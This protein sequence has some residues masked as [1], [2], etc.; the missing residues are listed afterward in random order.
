LAASTTTVVGPIDGRSRPRRI[1]TERTW[2]ARAIQNAKLDVLHHGGGTLPTT[3]AT[4][5]LPT[6]VTMHDAQYL[7]FPDTFSKAKLAWLRYSV[8]RAMRA[9]TVVATPSQYV[10]DTIVERFGIASDRVVVVPNAAPSEPAAGARDAD[11][12]AVDAVRARYGL[13][14][15]FVVYPAITYAHKNHATLLRAFVPLL[16]RNHDRKLVLLGGT[17]P[18]ERDVL[19]LVTELGLTKSVVRPGRVPASDRDAL[20]RGA[21]C[22][23]FPSRYEGFGVPVLEA[24]ALR[25]PVVASSST[26]LPEAVGDAGLL[27]DPDDVAGWSTAIER[28]LS[29]SALAD[30]L[31][32]R[33]D[34]RAAA[35]TPLVSARALAAAYGRALD[36]SPTR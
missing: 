7:T 12:D 11:V 5:A 26:A 8:P 23:A 13:G 1:Q 28:V 32:A 35:F 3:R 2:L 33:G 19:N 15:E 22:L 10:A 16:A 24:F 36:L 27:V 17:G 6:V 20:V 34:R 25:C 31:R 4:R 18:A 14:G 21:S 9:A 30:D 29:D